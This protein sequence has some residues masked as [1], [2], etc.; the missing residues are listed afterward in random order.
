MEPCPH[1]HKELDPQL[2]FVR[3]SLTELPNALLGWERPK[4]KRARKFTVRCPHCSRTY[5]SNT[6]RRFGFVTHRNYVYVVGL[7][8]LAAVM[9]MLLAG[10]KG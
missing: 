9:L 4:A 3:A 6:L 5:V 8:C 1:C 10:P 7:V 2:H